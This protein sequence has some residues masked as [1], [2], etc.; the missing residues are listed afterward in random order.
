MNDCGN[1]AHAAEFADVQLARG[2][3][4]NAPD[5][6][7]D[8]DFCAWLT[9]DEAK[10]TWVRE[11]RVDEWSDVVVLVDPSLSGEGS[12]SMMPAP[13]W[14]RIIAACRLYLGRALPRNVIIWCA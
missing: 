6:F 5:L 7:A 13:S 2:L 12:D 10:F 8:P 11:G 14:D 4:I 9:I 3:V 1:A